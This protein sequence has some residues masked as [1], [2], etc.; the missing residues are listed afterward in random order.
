MKASTEEVLRQ[1]GLD[2]QAVQ[3]QTA[4][5]PS[6]VEAAAAKVDQLQQQLSQIDAVL[7]ATTSLTA[8]LEKDRENNR[9]VQEMRDRRLH[10]IEAQL[11]ACGPGVRVRE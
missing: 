9:K 11:V 6:S 4:S 5:V 1:C 3:S 10:P 8:T 2:F 7:L